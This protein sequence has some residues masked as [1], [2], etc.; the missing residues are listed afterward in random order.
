ME[1][2]AYS[3]YIDVDEWG[4]SQKKGKVG[5]A[6]ATETTSRDRDDLEVTLLSSQPG[7]TKVPT[8]DPN[9][10]PKVTEITDLSVYHGS[11]TAEQVESFLHS[12]T[13]AVI[14][15]SHCPFCRDVLDLL[16]QQLGVAVAV[17]QLDKLTSKDG[18]TIHKYII[19]THKHKTV[20]AVFCRGDFLGG[21]ED[22][23]KLRS[24]GQLEREILGGLI[25]K[26]QTKDTQRV[27]T[28]HLIPTERSQAINPPFWFPNVVNNYVV[29][30]TGFQVCVLAVLSAAFPND[31]W[32]RY[33]AVALLIDF[34]LRFVAG[35]MA[36]PL[37]MIATLVTSPFRPQFKPG[38]SKQFAAFCGTFFSL[39][40]TI[41]YFVQFEGHQYVA[42]AFMAGLAGASGLEWAFD[43]CLG[44]LFYSWGIMFGLIPDHVYRIYTSTKQEIEDS[45]DY[46][47]LNSNAPPPTKQ[48][49]DPKSPI[50]LKYKIK[51]DEWTKDDFHIVRNMQVSYF[52][53]PL[54]ILA[55]AVAF[56]M[57]ADFSEMFSTEE[58]K[59]QFVAPDELYI[60]IGVIGGAVFLLWT[61][62]YSARMAMHPHKCIAEWDCPMRSPSFGAFTICIMLIAML[63]HD[64]VDHNEARVIF[65]IGALTHCVLTIAKLGEWVGLRHELEHVHAQWMMLPVGLAVAALICPMIPMFD[66][67]NTDYN[68]LVAPFFQSLAVVMWIV[69]FV[70]NFLKVV[71]THNSDDRLRHGVF[72][73]VAAPA[74]IGLAEFSICYADGI[75]PKDQ[76]NATFVNYF[77]MAMFLFLILCWSTLPYIGFLGRDKFGMQYWIGCFS[78]DALAACAA[79]MYA[80]YGY[81]AIETIM[82]IGLVLASIANL[83]CFLHT[84]AAMIRRRGVFTP[85]QKWGPLSFMKLTHEAVR[86]NMA[87]LRAALDFMD[88]HEK[89]DTAQ[90]HLN[91]FAAHFNRLCIVHDEHSK[92][93]DDVIF[94]EFNDWFSKHAKKF[95]DDHED[96]HKKI[97]LFKNMANSLL[98]KSLPLKDRQE[99][100][101]QLKEE[102][103]PFL[104][105]FL[106]HMK[107]EEYHLQPI[108]RKYLPLAIQ[109]EISRQVFKVTS[110]ENWE[111]IIPFVLNNLPRH[112]QRVRYLKVL[113][114][115]MPE[116][117]Q[118]IGAMVFRNVDAVMWERLRVEVPEMIPRGATN[119]RRYY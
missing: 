98:D 61:F 118:Q 108:G 85:E 41:F 86:G 19:D 75:Y 48:D 35:S 22:V 1:K 77:F 81:N 37:G 91:L 50:S 90:G 40:G 26:K 87:T 16:A 84:L 33:T 38:P 44:C 46:M 53:M 34:V 9:D 30:V 20:P 72:I 24:N 28:S 57:A 70:I 47:F 62:L 23:K 76:C 31:A 29:R 64:E 80:I 99:A 89:S 97:V 107:G 18:S 69:L 111:V 68:V 116:R 17:I 104:D 27:E 43:F 14:A 58:P 79:L 54:A 15:K 95:N 51:T 119:W 4:A 49:S 52:A 3:G 7:A 115:S 42:S 66:K 60:V 6:E 112:V 74:V 73:W 88:L 13:V 96:F 59:R 114:W 21:C 78:L 8:E 56:K 117:G 110:A 82:L 10:H 94:K 32:G 92:H 93:E 55:W 36:S 100:L 105:L 12:H 83:V 5:S 103:P 11:T 63:I 71:T 65:W 45:W 67:D 25:R 39:M 113:L 106:D 109:K 2:D 101:D 102:L